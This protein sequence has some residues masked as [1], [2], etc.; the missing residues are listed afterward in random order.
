MPCAL[1][2]V[3]VSS[4][5]SPAPTMSTVWSRSLP[6]TCRASSTAA[7]LTLTGRSPM[8]VSVRTRLPTS[9]ACRKRRLKTTLVQPPSHACW[10]AALSWATICASPTTIESRLEV[11]RNRWAMAPSP[12]KL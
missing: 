10:Y 8:A 11:T 6:N 5:V 12:E 3:A 7:E 4:L 9:S 2:C 1:R